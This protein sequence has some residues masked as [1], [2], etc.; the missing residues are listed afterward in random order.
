[1]RGCLCVAEPT[2][3]RAVAVLSPRQPRLLCM[4]PACCRPGQQ[5]GG[6]AVATV[7]RV[8]HEGLH[9]CCTVTAWPMHVL[10]PGIPYFSN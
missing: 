3:S 2:V 7:V 9:D 8:G 10:L 5:S 4:Q 6:L 1:M